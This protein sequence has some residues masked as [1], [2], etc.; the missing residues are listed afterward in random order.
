[1]SQTDKMPVLMKFLKTQM[2]HPNYS[3]QTN[4]YEEARMT[5]NSLSPLSASYGES[6]KILQMSQNREKKLKRKRSI[7]NIVSSYITPAPLKMHHTDK[8]RDHI[9]QTQNECGESYT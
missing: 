4:Y 5:V 9:I 7:Y 2:Q 8:H 3:M 6:F 1:M